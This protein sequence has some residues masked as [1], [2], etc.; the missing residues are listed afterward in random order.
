VRVYAFFAAMRSAFYDVPLTLL[1]NNKNNLQIQSAASS[2]TE[3][4]GVCSQSAPCLV[5]IMK[6]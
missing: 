2:I 1:S 5:I 6:I 4:F 3:G